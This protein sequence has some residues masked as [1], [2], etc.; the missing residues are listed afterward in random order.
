MRSNLF[1]KKLKKMLHLKMLV[2]RIPQSMN[3]NMGHPSGTCRFGLDPNKSVLD[4]NNRSHDLA[5]L[6]I[7]DSSFFPTSGGTNPSLTIAANAL[8]IA[9]TVINQI[10][11]EL[12]K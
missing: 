3:L 6:F 7:C 2:V 12:A 9:P 8:R 1:Y 11:T 5:N 4:K 10:N